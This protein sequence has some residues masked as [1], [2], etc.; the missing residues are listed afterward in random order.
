LV[1]T[2]LGF[3]F[4]CGTSANTTPFALAT[5]AFIM[6]SPCYGSRVPDAVQHEVVHR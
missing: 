3:G 4:G 6:F 5:P 2:S 1:S